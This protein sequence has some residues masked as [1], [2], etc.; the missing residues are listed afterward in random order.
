MNLWKVSGF[1]IIPFFASTESKGVIHHLNI[2]PM[3][4]QK[5]NSGEHDY[6]SRSLEVT[7]KV[8]LVIALTVWCFMIL[9]PFLMIILWSVILTVAIY[10]LFLW[11]K[12]KLGNRGKL[13]A[14]LV[15]LF[16]L[17]LILVPVVM[18]GG[19][20]AQAV[21]YMKESLMSGKSMIPPPD[22]AVRAWP[23]VGPTLF[24]LWQ[25]AY[26]N[27]AGFAVEHK[28]QLLTG[29]SWFLSAITNAGLG[30]LILLGSIIISGILLVFADEGA[31]SLRRIAVR[32]MGERGN[33]VVSNAE[34][35]IR[36][37]ARG[38]L[39]V[40]FI[41]A[42]L[43]GAGLLVA[44][45]PGAGLWALVSFFLAIIQIGVGPV[46]LGALIYAWIK[47][48]TLTAI[49]LTVY[50]IIPMTVDNILKP[51][52]LGRKAPAPMLVVFLGAIGG[53]IS[54]GTIGLFVGAVVLSL[55]YYLFNLWL[56]QNGE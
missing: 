35:T 41:Q 43:V 13:S 52:L 46:V 53:F 22:E 21:I 3:E 15:T 49:L 31:G 39:G 55:G 14:V 34:V 23:L 40:A 36:N 16:L 44:G 20:L 12:K 33:E 38:I 26:E 8:G 37:V 50:C 2:W 5:N 45:I 7:I 4:L 24:S 30:M 42:F 17:L 19:S 27:L 28:S 9:K 1:K 18:L 29:L 51:V 32:L 47:F 10:P 48:S 25:S 56:D 54:F 6:V 11:L